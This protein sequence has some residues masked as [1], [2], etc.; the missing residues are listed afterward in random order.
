M[1]IHEKLSQA[2]QSFKKLTEGTKNTKCFLKD[3]YEQSIGSHSL[4]EARVLKLLES[5]DEKNRLTLYYLG[6]EIVA[7]RKHL[8]ITLYNSYY[9]KLK[10]IPK[11][12]ASV[13]YGFCEHHDN[14]IFNLLDNYVYIDENQVNYLHSYRAF[15][16]FISQWVKLISYHTNSIEP[17]NAKLNES[18]N[19]IDEQF[20]KV[21][22]LNELNIPI[23]FQLSECHKDAILS[24]IDSL[25]KNQLFLNKD[26]LKNHITSQ[27]S[28]F[29][30]PDKVFTGKEI[31]HLLK[32]SLNDLTNTNP[33]Q[34]F[35]LL[36]KFGFDE[37]LQELEYI[38]HK[39]E[40]IWL[41]GA[42]SEFISVSISLPNL[43]LITGCFVY[44]KNNINIS[45]T[46][47]P[48]EETMKT[49]LIFGSLDEK[50]SIYF[51]QLKITSELELKF[52][53]TRLILERGSNLYISPKYWS[54]LPS[55]IK[56]YWLEKRTKRNYNQTLNI[57]E[58]TA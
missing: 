5:E 20:D 15:S 19:N 50:A 18:I 9:Q 33:I 26:Q 40:S 45:L 32:E 52:Y 34:D 35:N 30:E 25:S 39:I 46:I 10:S 7:D 38:K 42:F 44:E 29:L 55:E 6:N 1:N 23:D 21:P 43:F 11:A 31:D 14:E 12:K 57:F 48:E 28:S 16:Y 37:K 4:S 49:H 47:L 24:E 36:L 56:S 53:I 27:F 2:E 41:R 51:S 58:T 13:F 22:D 3:C 8:E 17:L 54:T